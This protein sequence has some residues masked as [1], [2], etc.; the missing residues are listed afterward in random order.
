VRTPRNVPGA[1]RLLAGL[2]AALVE[3]LTKDLEPVHIPARAS[4]VE[5]AEELSHVYFITS[6]IVSRIGVTSTGRSLELAC[7]GVEGAVGV[8]GALGLRKMPYRIIAQLPS[9]ALRI[10]AAAFRRHALGAPPL[11]ERV[12]AYG[13]VVI[14]QLAQSAICGRFH[15]SS[16]RLCRWLVTAAAR[17]EVSRLPWS[18]EW[19]AEMVGG[20]RSAVS[21]AA[22]ALR[23]EGLVE[24]S[25]RGVV[26]RDLRGLRKKACE[27]LGIV[28]GAIAAFAAG[29]SDTL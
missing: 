25:R 18:H 23:D 29:Q 22:A 12:A 17:A 20:P 2:D 11:V 10:P 19:I 1:N 4:L 24:Y 6:G 26:I 16:Q 28:E 3:R 21:Q 8:L 15:T 9:E 13:S 7:T 14:T 5:H 27:C